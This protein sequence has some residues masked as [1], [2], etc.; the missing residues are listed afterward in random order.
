MT[1]GKYAARSTLRREDA[2]VRSEIESY[3]HA[4][5][6]LTSE[7]KHLTAQL[8][9]E[10]KAHREDVRKLKAQLNEGLSPELLVLR[11]ELEHQRE[12]ADRAVAD[13]REIQRK[14]D[15]A[16]DGMLKILEEQHRGQGV[17]QR[18][19]KI[20]ALDSLVELVDPGNPEKPGTLAGVATIPDGV[21]QH[22]GVEGVKR[23]DQARDLG[24]YGP[25]G[26]RR[27]DAE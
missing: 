6:R 2:S 5:K 21:R 9:E 13:R 3:K 26:R 20:N 8:D 14:W 4:V 10:Q 24:Y 25:V 15:N 23:I 27:R 19:A 16:S 11:E 22:L 18:S 7:N 1:R 12:R 17:G